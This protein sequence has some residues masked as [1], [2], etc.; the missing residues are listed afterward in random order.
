VRFDSAKGTFTLTFSSDSGIKE[1]T[2]IFVPTIQFPNGA[3]IDALGLKVVSNRQGIIELLAETPG[4]KVVR[5][6]RA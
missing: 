4:E 6:T 5:L 3:H 1:P 2:E